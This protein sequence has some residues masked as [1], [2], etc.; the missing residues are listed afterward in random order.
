VLT[1]KSGLD[2]HMIKLWNLNVKF[3]FYLYSLCYYFLNLVGMSLRSLVIMLLIKR[4]S[5]KC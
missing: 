1:V 4:D 5:L 2:P 3:L